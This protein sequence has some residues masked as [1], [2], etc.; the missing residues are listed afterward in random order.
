MAVPEATRGVHRQAARGAGWRGCG[1]TPA[2]P[3]RTIS[4]VVAQ[5]L[6]EFLARGRREP[7]AQVSDRA[8]EAEFVFGRH[9]ATELSV[10]YAILV[11]Q[12]RARIARAGQEGRPPR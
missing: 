10:A 2:R 6:E 7:S 1:R 8:V 9:A 4:A 3:E 5:A 11:P 12:R